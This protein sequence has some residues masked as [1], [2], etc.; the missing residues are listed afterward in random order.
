MCSVLPLVFYRLI[1]HRRSRTLLTAGCARSLPFP[2]LPSSTRHSPSAQPR[3]Q[4]PN[5]ASKY[6]IPNL[7]ESSSQLSQTPYTQTMLGRGVLS[8][9]L[10]C[11]DCLVKARYRTRHTGHTGHTGAGGRRASRGG[12]RGREEGVTDTRGVGRHTIPV[13]LDVVLSFL[14]ELIVDLVS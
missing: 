13:I 10:A 12:G 9:W 5:P 1:V 8:V 11:K 6:Q 7:P 2:P 4:T 3:L 14:A